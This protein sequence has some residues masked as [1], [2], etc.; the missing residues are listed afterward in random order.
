MKMKVLMTVLLSVTIMGCA[1]NKKE[2]GKKLTISKVEVEK[3]VLPGKT[4]KSEVINLLGMP[5]M[6]NTNSKKEE[7]WVY[8]KH[9][10]E[11][12]SGSFGAGVFGVGFLSSTLIGVDVSGNKS[13]G[14]HSSKMKTLTINFT[15]KGLVKDFNFSYSRI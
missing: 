2:E 15:P 3:H 13:S 5:E 8:S 4:N 6:V 10:N 12:E 11:S 14:Q 7:Q 1:S 9:L